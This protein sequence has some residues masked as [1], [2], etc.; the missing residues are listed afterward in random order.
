[1]KRTL[2]ASL[3]HLNS[4]SV[5]ARAG[6][7]LELESKEDLLTYTTDYGFDPQ[8]DLILGGG[9]NILLTGDIEGTVVLNR[10]PGKRIV[11]ESD[12]ETLVEAYAGENWHQLVLWS[13]EQGLSG[14]EN[15]SLIPGLAGCRT[16]PEYRCL[17][18]GTG[19][20]LRL[21]AGP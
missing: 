19:R 14:I 6:R 8:H 9:S 5:E 17:W 11:V 2:N 16:Y 12:N 10:V 20:H 1:M 4:F 7:L 3:K 13:L 15:L 21:T 18:R